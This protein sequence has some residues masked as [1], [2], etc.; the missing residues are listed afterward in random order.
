LRGSPAKS[1]KGIRVRDKGARQ[2]SLFDDGEERDALELAPVAATSSATPVDLFG[3]HVTSLRLLEEKEKPCRLNEWA[4]ISDLTLLRSEVLLCTDCPLRSGAKNVVFGDGDPHARVMLIGEAPGQS[5]DESGKPFVGRAGKLL[6][7]ILGEAGLRREEVFIGN[8][9][10]C[11]PPQNRLP[12]PAEVRA[13]LPHLR[14]QM[15]IIRPKFVVLLGALSS[16][17]LVDPS[18][19]VTRDRGKWFEKDGV[20]YL[21]TFHPAAVLRDEQGKRGLVVSDMKS[22]KLKL[23]RLCRK[24]D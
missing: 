3:D 24:T 4:G 22:L 9:A 21:V 23:D 5:E 20:D 12:D 14:A 19:R 17:T 15:R 13:C 10:K 7:S 11:R 2:I 6:D 1:R 18:L 16:Q 8:I